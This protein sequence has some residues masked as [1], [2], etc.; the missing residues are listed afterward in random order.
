MNNVS[1]IWAGIWLFCSL[2]NPLPREQFV[3]LPRE[4]LR[5]LSINIYWMKEVKY[6]SSSSSFSFFGCTPGT[7]TFL[8]QE[9]NPHRRC[10][11]HHS[12]GNAGSLTCCTTRE[13]L[14]HLS[15]V[16]SQ[17]S[18]SLWVWSTTWSGPYH[19]SALFCKSTCCLFYSQLPQLHLFIFIYLLLLKILFV[20]S[21]HAWFPRFL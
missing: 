2:L 8:G 7:G 5:Q 4:Q 1:S 3:P 15:C 9:L 17:P 21:L 10:N 18:G 12:C 13:L 14:S 6:S 20:K 16:C 11:L 19:V